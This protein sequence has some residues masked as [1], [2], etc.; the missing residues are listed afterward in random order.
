MILRDAPCEFMPVELV[1]LAKRPP[2]ISPGAAASRRLAI[3]RIKRFSR[4]ASWLHA[5]YS[6]KDF[7]IIARLD[8]YAGAAAR[9]FHPDTFCIVGKPR[10]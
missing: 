5:S 2:P 10:S 3:H 8:K 1:S 6:A 7:V 4:L 9:D